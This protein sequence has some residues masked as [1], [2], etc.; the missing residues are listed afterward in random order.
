M[1]PTPTRLTHQEEKC[2]L[3]WSALARIE[4]EMVSEEQRN[5]HK[6]IPTLFDR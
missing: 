1:N 2:N 5:N 3:K 4:Q 6:I